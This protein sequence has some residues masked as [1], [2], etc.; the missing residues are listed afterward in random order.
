MP[1]HSATERKERNSRKKTS[2]R[3]C[4]VPFCKNLT[5]VSFPH[6]FL[7]FLLT[8]K[9]I[10]GYLLKKLQLI[11]AKHVFAHQLINNFI[12]YQ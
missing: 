11:I 8:L 10:S 12:N 9:E 7:R 4:A 6:V 3:C 5:K 1:R 2:F